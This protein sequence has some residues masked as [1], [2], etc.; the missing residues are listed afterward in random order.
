MLC[1]KMGGRFQT[2]CDLPPSHALTGQLDAALHE[3]ME[4]AVDRGGDLIEHI[5]NGDTIA[6]AF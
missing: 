5:L 4:V 6:Q 3:V 2:P 1:M